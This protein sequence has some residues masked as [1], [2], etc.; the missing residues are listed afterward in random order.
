MNN[1]KINVERNKVKNEKICG[2]K[3][4]KLALEREKER[5]SERGNARKRALGLMDM[6]VIVL[7]T[8]LVMPSRTDIDTCWLQ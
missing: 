2:D 6:V 5:E 4:Q 7:Y 8:V 1:N 3:K